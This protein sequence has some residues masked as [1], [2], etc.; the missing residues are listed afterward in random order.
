MNI[1]YVLTSDIANFRGSTGKIAG[2]VEAWRELGHAV[3][4]F[5]R[6][7]NL[8]ESPLEAE[9]FLLTGSFVR[10]NL[11]RNRPMVSAIESF[12]PD[13]VYFRAGIANATYNAVAS[14]FPSV[15]EINTDD[16]EETRHLLRTEPSLR[17]AIRAVYTLFFRGTFLRRLRGAVFITQELRERRRFSKYFAESVVVP[18]S[19]K[20]SEES[21]DILKGTDAFDDPRVH[22][23][24]IGS[25]GFV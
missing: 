9:R 13:V 17:A 4:V 20:L 1:A 16:I 11:S 18:N 23:F 12:K 6:T 14:R 22:L 24:F 5:A 8:D 7:P 19:V 2:Q 15:V 10:D 21:A 25:P 3:K